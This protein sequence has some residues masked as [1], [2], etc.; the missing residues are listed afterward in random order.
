MGIEPRRKEGLNTDKCQRSLET[1]GQISQNILHQVLLPWNLP[2][3]QDVAKEQK[4]KA[5][6][7][8]HLGSL[9]QTG[10]MKVK[11]KEIQM[12]E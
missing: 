8:N 11:K 3:I 7:W 4:W 9:E 2:E 10:V 5:P 1:G 6:A 12:K